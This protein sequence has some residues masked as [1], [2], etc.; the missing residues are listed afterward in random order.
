MRNIFSFLP[1]GFASLSDYISPAAFDVVDW[2]AAL[3]KSA[4]ISKQL[5]FGS[6]VDELCKDLT[7]KGLPHGVVFADVELA[8][9]N[10][11]DDWPD[12]GERLL[13]LYFRQ[14]IWH[15]RA[16]LDLRS[17]RFETGASFALGDP[18]R[19]HPNGLWVTFNRDFLT[20]MREVYAGFYG[21]DPSKVRHGLGRL[22]LLGDGLSQGS[23]SQLLALLEDHFGA[24]R[25]SPMEFRVS[26]FMES[27]DKLFLFLRNEKIS[28]SEDFLFLGVMLLTLYLH[29]ESLGGHHD[30]RAAFLRAQSTVSR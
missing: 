24:G 11:P 21:D 16:F 18:L 1:R 13:E 8:V 9:T 30:V 5:L 19:W 15:D 20:G 4:V 10:Q 17:E 26:H 25:D 14:I 22:G 23:R 3:R 28:L 2:K 29:L 7:A 6:K 27:F 12:H